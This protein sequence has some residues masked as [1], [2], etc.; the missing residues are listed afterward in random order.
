MEISFFDIENNF[1]SHKKKLPKRVVSIPVIL[2][3]GKS[4]TVTVR[5]PALS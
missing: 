4:I 5:I 2:G 1:L 3:I